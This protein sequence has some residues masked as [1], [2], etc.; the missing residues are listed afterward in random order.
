M[1]IIDE[2]HYFPF[3]AVKD[4]NGKQIESPEQSTASH[5]GNTE[6]GLRI[7]GLTAEMS[8]ISLELSFYP[9]WIKGEGK[10]RIR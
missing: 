7:P 3:A 1:H 2:F 6:V 9:S 8:P 10:I 5:D 4:K